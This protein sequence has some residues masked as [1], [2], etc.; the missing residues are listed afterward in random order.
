MYQIHR[1]DVIEWAKGY[2]GEPFHAML[3]DCPYHL[4]SIA[5]R[6]GKE[7]S[8]PAKGDVYQRA[9]AGFMNQTWDGLGESGMGIA[10]DPAT[11]AALSQHLYPGA[12]IMAFASSRGWHRMAVAMEDAGLIIQPTIWMYWAYLSGFPKATRV[13][14]AKEF[15]GHRYGGQALKP[16]IE[17]II[18]AQVPYEGRPVEN[19]VATGAGSL[20]IDGGRIPIGETLPSYRKPRVAARGSTYQ[21]GETPAGNH[22]DSVRHNLAGRWPSN[23]ILTH[24][25]YCNGECHPDCPVRLFDEQA[26][27]RTSSS[28]DGKESETAF[29]GSGGGGT[30]QEWK[31]DSGPASRMFYQAGWEYEVAEQLANAAP[32]RY[33]PKVSSSEREAGLEGFE[34]KQLTGQDKWAAKDRRAGTDRNPTEWI[35]EPIRNNHPTLKPVSLA[36]YLA[37]LLSPP[38]AYAPRRILIPFSGSGSEICGAILSGGFEEII[39]IEAEA[40]Y[41]KI[42]EARCSW[43]SQWPG[44][45]QTDVEAIL[46]AAKE[47]DRQLSLFK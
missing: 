23:F 26:G 45:G 8:A 41:V 35:K 42:A 32:V 25:E 47:D 33:E 37:T 9:S 36:K 44:W 16:S 30:S 40:N 18:V 13:K 6:F 19:I 43:W 15:N 2:Q 11:W 12:F 5:K 29:F 21:L 14:G 3:T 46:A 24:H 34:V 31:A 10:F 4:T 20:W 22:P 39:G 17:P 7:G 27:V 28:R 38:A 1:Q